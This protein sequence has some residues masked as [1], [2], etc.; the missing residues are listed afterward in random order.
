MGTNNSAE[1]TAAREERFKG[2][3][4]QHQPATSAQIKK[5]K[6]PMAMVYRLRNRGEL[7]KVTKGNGKGSGKTGAIYT[8][9]LADPS[10]NGNGH[11]PTPKLSSFR[12]RMDQT[13]RIAQASEILFGRNGPSDYSVYLSWVDLTKEMM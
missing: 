7:D 8:Y 3:M 6:F 13:A 12:A 2:W 11:A 5:A 9:V 1:A 10:T 4:R